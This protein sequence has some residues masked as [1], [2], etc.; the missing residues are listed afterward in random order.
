MKAA[1]A[2]HPDCSSIGTDGSH[3]GPARRSTTKYA[4]PAF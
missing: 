3:W 4:T 1:C 2:G